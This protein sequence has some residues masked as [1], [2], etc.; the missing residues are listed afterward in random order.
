MLGRTEEAEKYLSRITE[1]RGQNEDAVSAM[2][3]N[4]AAAFIEFRIL[5]K[6]GQVKSAAAKIPKL[7]ELLSIYQNKILVDTELSILFNIVKCWMLEG[8][9]P[10]ALRA[11]NFLMSHPLL[12]KRADYESYLRIMN[13]IIHFEMKNYELLRYLIISTYR[14]LSKREKL[15]RLE[16]LVLEFIRKLPEVKNDDDLAFSFELFKKKLIVLKK[17][18][19]ERNAFEYFDF[20]SWVESNAYSL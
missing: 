20:L 15:Y 4:I 18:R 2:D 14:F 16:M 10:E 9:F 3:H 11:A 13:L 8:N 1:M 6:K 5:L 19:Y 7:Y 17:D 12:D